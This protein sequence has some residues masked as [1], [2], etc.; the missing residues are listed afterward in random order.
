MTFFHPVGPLNDTIQWHDKINWTKLVIFVIV[1]SIRI[2]YR[3]TCNLKITNILLVSDVLKVLSEQLDDYTLLYMCSYVLEDGSCAPF[4]ST[5]V[6]ASRTPNLDQS[7]VGTLLPNIGESC[8]DDVNFE[9]IPQ[10]RMY[11]VE[12]NMDF[13]ISASEHNSSTYIIPILWHESSNFNGQ[14]SDMT[15]TIAYI[16]LV[17]TPG[18]C[19]IHKSPRSYLWINIWTKVLILRKVA[20]KRRCERKMLDIGIHR[21]NR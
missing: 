14:I 9:M 2:D 10:E 18:H 3:L 17:I 16:A 20:D 1:I 21:P 11:F 15:N 7:L 19:S 4:A 6:L 8:I 13:I 5:I 12:Q